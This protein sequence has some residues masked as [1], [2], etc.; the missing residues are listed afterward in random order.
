MA[1]FTAQPGAAITTAM[2]C[3]GAVS[4]QFIAGKATRDALFLA[5]MDVTA[6]PGM[7]MATAALSI[8]LVALSS[9]ILRRVTPDTFVPAAFVLNAILL[10]VAWAAAPAAPAWSAQMVYLQMSGLGPMLGSGFWLIATD[11]FDPH[12]A[13]HQF[14]RIAGIATLAG[15]GGALLMHI[16]NEEV[17]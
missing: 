15:H 2:V 8:A 17:E 11:Q 7:V 16:H 10:L 12:T 14:G 6:L 1:L 9:R 3:A 4:A 13:R 5:T